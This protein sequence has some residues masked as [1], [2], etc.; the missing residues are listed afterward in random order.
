[1]NTTRLQL[2]LREWWAH[3]SN[4]T[5]L[6]FMGAAVAL[7]TLI[8]PFELN[9]HLPL[10]KAVPYWA[11]II[12]ATYFV[13]FMVNT[14]LGAGWR[15]FVIGTLTITV[16]VAVIVGV[17]NWVVFKFVP[18]GRSFF[19]F[20][21]T[22]SGVCVIV[23]AVFWRLNSEI[24]RAQDVAKT[25][26]VLDRLP[27]DKR[28]ALVALSVEDHYVRVRTVQ[29]EEMVL[30]RLGDA[31]REAAP[32]A[33]LQVHRSHWVALDQVR[34]AR[35]EGDRAVLSMTHGP[36]IPVSRANMAAIRDAGLLPGAAR[37]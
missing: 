31:V 18:S 15:N 11:W 3:V 25:P 19:L 27:L 30:M 4:P 24:S 6:V 5:A 28:G 16:L 10:Y 1:M 14:V 9:A 12:L 35:R 26:A 37:G 36:D 22:T 34:A 20:F 33:G 23:N 8:G 7:L 2:A 32:C 13:G 21:A 29:G 17:T